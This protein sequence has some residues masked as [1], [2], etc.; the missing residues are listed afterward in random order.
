M[1]FVS[2]WKLERAA[3]WIVCCPCIVVCVPLHILSNK[4]RNKR[5]AEQKARDERLDPRPPPQTPLLPLPAERARRLTHAES[6]HT[7]QQSALIIRIPVEVRLLIW[8][9]LL[10]RETNDDVLHLDLSHGSLGHVRC[11]ESATAR[12]CKLG[13]QHDCWKAFNEPS[14]GD[15]GRASSE[16]RE[17]RNLQSI[18]LTCKLM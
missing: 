12:L 8:E 17:K 1:G 3:L 11:Y 4:K 9:H 10:G 5:K 14:P 13:Y 15:I 7:Q 16:Q 18:L 2:R 6:H